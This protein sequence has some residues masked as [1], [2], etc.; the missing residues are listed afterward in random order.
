MEYT[1]RSGAMRELNVTL[2]METQRRILSV[3]VQFICESPASEFQ[4]VRG[5]FSSM[6]ESFRLVNDRL[7]LPDV[8][9]ANVTRCGACGRQFATSD[10]R[11][12]VYDA[13]RRDLLVLCENCRCR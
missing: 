13:S 3:R 11:H 9:L 4:G 8:V 2:M 12:T 5:V 7:A 10:A 6:I 1:Y